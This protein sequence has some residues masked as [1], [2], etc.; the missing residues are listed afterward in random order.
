MKPF[1]VTT[2]IVYPNASPH[3]GFAYELVMGDVLAR[4]HRL[5]GEDVFFLTG[6]DEHG[7]KIQD[8]AIATGKTPKEF[9]DCMAGEFKEL[10]A[11]WNIAY[12]RFVRTTDPDHI[13]TAQAMF[14]KLQDAGDIYLG[15]YEGLYCVGCEAFY[16][17]KDAPNNECPTHKKTLQHVQEESYF[18]KLSKYQNKIL[19]LLQTTDFILPTQ[20]RQEIINRVKE[21][22][23]DLSVSRT[24]FAWGI[25]VP[26]NP[27]HVIYVWIDALPNYVSGIG[28]PGKLFDKYWPPIHIVGKDILWFHA[29]IWPAIL[30]SANIPLPKHILTH[31]FITLGGEKMSKSRGISVDPV[32]LQKTYGTDALRYYLLH[33]IPAG[34]DGDFTEQALVARVNADLADS[35][36]NLLQRATVL[37]KRSFDSSIPACGTLTGAEQALVNKAKKLVES[38]KTRMQVPDWNQALEDLW[39]FIRDCNKY[40]TEQEPWK[41]Q[42]K[43]RL[44]TILYTTVEC[45]RIIGILAWPFVPAAAEQLAKQLGQK[46]LQP[47]S[48]AVFTTK[49]TGTIPEPKILFKKLELVTKKD[50]FGMLN[51]KVGI[52][53][54]VE[55]HPNAEKLY[56]VRVDLGSEERQ[57]CAGIKQ[58]YKPEELLGK[59]IVVLTNL[60]PAK[61]RGVESQ[62][63]MLAAEKN[64]VVRVLE[65][66]QAPAGT[67]VVLPGV[68][69]DT[70]QIT[71]EDFQT[72]KLTTKNNSPM[73][74]DR[75]LL[76]NE[77]PVVVELDDGAVIR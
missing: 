62:G 31:G 44:G 7:Q 27:K 64:G 45:L 40:V 65:A 30:L 67:P 11:S 47:L 49:T 9:V 19:D 24:S 71:I 53:K 2:A 43:E 52:V 22:L 73:Y 41:V 70:N 74:D 10:C 37:I 17:E 4:W 26:G 39:A 59:H 28:Y 12:S 72:I 13:K 8:T 15:Q 25:P 60:K 42:D 6:T 46:E 55:N 63:M 57:L 21:G 56:V 66:A 36:G 14:K 50:P 33:E 51:L 16:L 75:P 32:A 69:Q 29:V 76:A 1:Y 20:Y 61:L 23:R 77:Q 58:W 35:L 34:Q 3:V 5:L 54:T 68:L 48:K 18:F 38:M